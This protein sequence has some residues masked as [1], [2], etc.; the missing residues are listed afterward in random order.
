MIISLTWKK[1]Y[2]PNSAAL[3]IIGNIA[4]SLCDI[5][6]GFSPDSYKGKHVIKMTIHNAPT[7]KKNQ[8]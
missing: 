1:I 4:A 8:L 5:V 3:A 7:A 2:N 6:S